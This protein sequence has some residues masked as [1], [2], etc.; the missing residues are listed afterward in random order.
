MSEDRQK[1]LSKLNANKEEREAN[2]L[3]R[4]KK[5]QEAA[6]AE[7]TRRLEAATQAIDEHAIA[8]RSFT[9]KRNYI[10]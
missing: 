7:S 10:L 5:E 9:R 8:M 3:A 4:K 2:A 1:F 6:D